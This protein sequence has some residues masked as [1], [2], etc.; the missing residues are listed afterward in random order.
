MVAAVRPEIDRS[1]Q[2]AQVPHLAA[3]PEIA[4]VLSN[5]TETGI[6]FD[7]ACRLSDGP[8]ARFPSRLT[9]LLSRRRRVPGPK[10]PGWQVIPCGLTGRAGDAL[11]A[12]VR[13][14]ARAWRM[15][16][17]FL[18]R[19]D[20]SAP[21][22]NTLVDRIATG[23]PGA[24][25]ADHDPGTVVVAAVSARNLRKVAILNGAHTARRWICPRRAPS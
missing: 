16:Q 18:D 14:H 10:A 13:D 15:P 17:A 12:M 8:P 6:V 5:T 19:L 11:A 1:A 7:P 9:A 23:A 22:C 4:V 20:A 2:G 25:R 24:D 3:R 21:I